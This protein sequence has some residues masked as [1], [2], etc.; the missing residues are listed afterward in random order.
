MSP[1]ARMTALV[2]RWRLG[3][4]RDS[5][6]A[7]AVERHLAQGCDECASAARTGEALAERIAGSLPTVEPSAFARARLR[8]ALGRAASRPRDDE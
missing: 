1:H 8:R 3:L 4:V 6:L 5:E 2:L 7:A